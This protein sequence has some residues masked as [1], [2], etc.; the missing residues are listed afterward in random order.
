M[1]CD[2]LLFDVITSIEA[3]PFGGVSATRTMSVYGK[4]VSEEGLGLDGSSRIDVPLKP[5]TCNPEEK[6]SLSV[7]GESYDVTV[8]WK[9]FFVGNDTYKVMDSLHEYPNHLILRTY[10]GRGY[11]IRCEEEGYRFSYVEKDGMLDCELKIHNK[12]GIQRI[13]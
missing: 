1:Y 4:N 11:F 6:A 7:A 2:E 8:S 13:L 10:S 12:N 3:Y 5:K 9:I